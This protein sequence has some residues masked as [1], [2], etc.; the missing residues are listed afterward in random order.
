MGNVD[1]LKKSRK[2]DEFIQEI[3]KISVAQ[4]CEIVGFQGFQESALDT[5]SDIA[6]KYI[7]DIGK[8][9]NIYANLAGRT[10]SNVFDVVRG[11]EDLGLSQGFVGGSDVDRCSSESG[12]V[13]EICQYV[14]VCGEVGF[15]Y[16]VPLFPVVK[17]RETL[18][19]FLN[20]GETPH[21]DNIPPW[22]PCFPDPETYTRLDSTSVEETEI[23]Q[24]RVDQDQ[25]VI[26]S[27]LM[28]PEL[29]L[30]NNGFH[31]PFVELGVNGGKGQVNNPFLASPLEYGEKVISLVSLPDRLVEED[32]DQNHCLWAKHVSSVGTLA[33]P[34][35]GFKS[36]DLDTEES[37]KEV[38]VERRPAVRLKFLT[39]K[40]SLACVCKN[41]KLGNP[42]AMFCSSNDDSRDDKKRRK[43]NIVKE[44]LENGKHYQND[45][46]VN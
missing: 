45:A 30:V 46:V 38:V 25:K 31:V 39:G 7:R 27:A 36:N 16:S 18:S 32:V 42:E 1:N 22:L 37:S 15:A 34:I 19:S 43:E 24:D 12:V 11:L 44:S 33:S 13:K 6:C 40:K 17:E 21:L 3:A 5:L 29:R 4:I 35:H 8:R 2:N 28:K 23:K 14:G 9:S 10:D 20:A 41:G 26:E